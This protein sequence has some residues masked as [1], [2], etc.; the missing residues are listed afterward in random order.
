FAPDTE[1][2]A[3][4]VAH[5]AG[6][7]HQ[8][9]TDGAVIG[10][11][12]RLLVRSCRQINH[13]ADDGANGGGQGAAHRVDQI[14]VEDA[15]VSNVAVIDDATVTDVDGAVEAR[16]V[17]RQHIEQ[18]KALELYQ[19]FATELFDAEFGRCDLVAIDQCYASA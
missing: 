8:A 7:H 2:S 4:D 5:A 15:L 12:H 17:L 19:L 6:E 1:A 11:R 16:R 3:Q 14:V 18:A 9:S 13:A 10:D